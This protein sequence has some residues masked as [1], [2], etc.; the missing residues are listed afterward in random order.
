M[1]SVKPLYQ[2]NDRTLVFWCRKKDDL[3][4]LYSP[5]AGSVC[6]ATTF[7]IVDH[8]AAQV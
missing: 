1:P 3:S 7:T 6:L 2:L 8:V 5:C 4:I